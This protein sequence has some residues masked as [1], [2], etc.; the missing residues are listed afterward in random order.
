MSGCYVQIYEQTYQR[1][2]IWTTWS[3]EMN[4]YWKYTKAYRLGRSLQLFQVCCNTKQ[5][6][7][8]MSETTSNLWYKRRLLESHG[9][10]EGHIP[11]VYSPL[12]K[13]E[14][15]CLRGKSGVVK[16]FQTSQGMHIKCCHPIEVL[17]AMFHGNLHTSSKCF[18]HSYIRVVM[19]RSDN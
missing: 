2:A 5:Q 17:V 12:P 16:Q 8:D 19:K 13:S 1:C 7:N 11:F 15:F 6:R 14:P 4:V 18:W 9:S 3:D 10:H